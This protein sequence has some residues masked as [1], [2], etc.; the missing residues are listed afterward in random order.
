MRLS[1]RRQGPDR[2][3][4][5]EMTQTRTA[6]ITAVACAAAATVWAG[7]LGRD[8]Q[9][10]V[11]PVS[12]IASGPYESW[13]VIGAGL[14]LTALLISA[15]VVGLPP[16]YACGAVTFGFTAAWTV[17]A[18]RQD[19]SG[20]FLVGTIMLLVGLTMGCAVVSVLTLLVRGRIRGQGGRHGV[21][22]G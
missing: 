22:V 6:G 4:H 12:R 15:L 9:Y 2:R 1:L 21:S 19:A 10:Q 8:D 13:Q 17:H 16:Q 14:C 18:A 5:G 11:D 3:Q 7:W 20:L